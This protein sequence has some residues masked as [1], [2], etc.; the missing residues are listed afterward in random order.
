MDMKAFAEWLHE[1][2]WL[3][4]GCVLKMSSEGGGIALEL[5]WAHGQAMSYSHTDCVEVELRQMRADVHKQVVRQ[6]L[7][8]A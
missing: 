1:M 8:P 6:M 3:T 4:G 2:Q 5:T 7:N